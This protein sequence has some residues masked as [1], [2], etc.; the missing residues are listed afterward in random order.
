MY[1]CRCVGIVI[2]CLGGLHEVIAL[3]NTRWFPIPGGLFV[4]IIC[5]PY[6][7]TNFVGCLHSLYV[8]QA[9]K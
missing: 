2:H 5:I 7:I 1:V 8:M 6:W 3:Q 4:D 9:L